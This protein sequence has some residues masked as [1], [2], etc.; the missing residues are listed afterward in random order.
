[1]I[2]QGVANR[3]EVQGRALVPRRA[4]SYRAAWRLCRAAKPGLAAPRVQ[5]RASESA[6]SYRAAAAAPLPVTFPIT[7]I[8]RS[9]PNSFRP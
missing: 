6:L 7:S 9:P 8:R 5:A 4:A 1:V 2:N 3:G